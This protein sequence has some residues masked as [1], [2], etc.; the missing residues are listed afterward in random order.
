MRASAVGALL[1]R[2]GSTSRPIVAKRDAAPPDVW[3]AWKRG[4]HSLV[5]DDMAPMLRAL[6][7]VLAWLINLLAWWLAIGGIWLLRLRH[8]PGYIPPLVPTFSLLIAIPV[9]IAVLRAIRRV[10]HQSRR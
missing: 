2:S 7:Y 10:G 6:G 4:P 9:N 3:S 5:L 1:P 8:R